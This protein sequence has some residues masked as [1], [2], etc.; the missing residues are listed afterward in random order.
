M[1]RR[2]R[3]GAFL[4]SSQRP[5]TPSTSALMLI[6]PSPSVDGQ[7]QLEHLL[8]AGS[9]Q[10]ITIC[11]RPSR[12]AQPGDR[13][14]HLHDRP[15]ENRCRIDVQLVIGAVHARNAEDETGDDHEVPR[16][17]CERRNRELVV[18]VEDPDDDPGDAEQRDNREEHLRKADQQRVVVRIE[19]RHHPRREENEERGQ[20]AEAEQRQPEERRRH[21][22]RALALAFFDQVAEHRDEGRRQRRIRDE[23]PDRVGDEERDVE[24][25]HGAVDAE[26]VLRDD[27]ADEPEDARESRGEREDRG[28]PGEPA[29][30]EV[31]GRRS[32][33]GCLA[34]GA[35]YAAARPRS[36]YDLS[37]ARSCGRF[38]AMA[39]I[40]QQKKRIRTAAEERL[41]NLRY[42]ST[43]KTLTKRLA[44]RGRRRRQVGGGH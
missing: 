33:L 26:V 6:R 20:T 5:I 37:P 17:G 35:R 9:R 21:A 13:Q 2:S 23:S 18:G 40:K 19:R 15:G 4:L 42:R 10:S 30:A 8:T 29:P 24:R 22:P 38:H 7:H 16:D 44:D 3:T 12:P 14:E 31:G 39:N 11:N 27:L 28:R 32:R 43:I 36:C 34:A 25:V 1:L 41:E